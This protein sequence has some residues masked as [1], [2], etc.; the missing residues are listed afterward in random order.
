MITRIVQR[1]AGLVLVL[2]A[3]AGANGQAFTFEISGENF[4]YTDAQRSFTGRLL[5]PA[6]SGPF[7]A[8]VF[9]HGQGGTPYTYPNLSVMRDWGAVVIATNLTHVAGGETALPERGAGLPASP[10]LLILVER[11]PGIDL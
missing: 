3:P 7:P 6:G 5:V 8:I 4:T 2:L 1:L 9:N 11:A 10:D